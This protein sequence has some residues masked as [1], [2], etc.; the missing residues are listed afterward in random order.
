MN[1]P[2][3]FIPILTDVVDDEAEQ[4][5]PT[6]E[7]KQWLCE[8]ET[9]FSAAIHEHADELVHNALREMEAVLLEHVSDR[10]KAE[11][12]TLVARIIDEHLRGLRNTN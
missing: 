1:H 7:A 8:L 5:L 6:G 2:T 10:L 3:D 12:P 11:L 9:H 4:V